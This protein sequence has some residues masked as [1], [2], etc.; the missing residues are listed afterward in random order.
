MSR[1]VTYLLLSSCADVAHGFRAIAETLNDPQQLGFGDD[2]QLSGAVVGLKNDFHRKKP[3]F[4]HRRLE[5]FSVPCVGW[6]Y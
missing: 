2:W 4:L 6:G 1:D 5:H 3:G